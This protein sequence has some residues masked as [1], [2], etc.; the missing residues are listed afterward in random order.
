M[1]DLKKKLQKNKGAAITLSAIILIFLIL[2]YLGRG[3]EPLLNL[4][5][6]AT[7]EEIDGA[8]L[9]VE[10]ERLKSLN[11]IDEEFLVSPLFESLIDSQVQVSAQP[12]GRT[13]PFAP[14]AF[15]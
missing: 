4:G 1:E 9:L 3:E 6:R 7:I 8:K 14:P 12:I 15:D 11:Q 2:W 5:E 13:N 10:L